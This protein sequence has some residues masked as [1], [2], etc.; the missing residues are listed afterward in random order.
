MKKKFP[1]KWRLLKK[2]VDFFQ[3]FVNGFKFFLNRRNRKFSFF[4][5]SYHRGIYKENP[6]QISRKSVDY[7]LRFGDKHF[8]KSSLEKKA[9]KVFKL[10]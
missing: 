2:E 1:A 9:F 4:V 8:A 5:D 3:L 10:V 7:N 6:C